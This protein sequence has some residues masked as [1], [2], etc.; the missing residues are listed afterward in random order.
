MI[1]KASH[2]AKNLSTNF[3]IKYERNTPITPIDQQQGVYFD[4]AYLRPL[5]NELTN[6]AMNSVRFFKD[7]VR[8]QELKRNAAAQLSKSIV[9]KRKLD[10]RNKTRPSRGLESIS[11]DQL[12]PNLA[13]CSHADAIKL[14]HSF[15]FEEK[16]LYFVRRC[17]HFTK[18]FK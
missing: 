11:F 17:M 15:D 8:P 14:T 12:S 6:D 18:K 7:F 9:R 1:L 4:N 16:P 10:K 13:P 5:F 2:V 3:F